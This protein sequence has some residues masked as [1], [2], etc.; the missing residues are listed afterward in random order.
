LTWTVTLA[1]LLAAVMHAGWNAAIKKG[2]EP[3]FETTLVHAWVALPAMLV[4]PWLPF[5]GETAAMCLLVS[6]S[7][8]CVYYNTMSSAYRSG[9]LSFAYPIMRGSAPML[10]AIAAGVVLAEWP[11]L[12][13]WLGIGAISAG[14][15]A[16]GLAVGPGGWSKNRRHSLG[17]ALATALTIVAYTVVDSIGARSAPSAWVYLAWLA[18]I[19]G[20][21]VFAMVYA[22][23]G[24]ALL[25][26]GRERGIAPLAIGVVSVGGY[27]IA[28]WAMTR[29][30]VALV[31]ALRETSVLFALLI[32]AWVLGERF[33]RMRWA[34]ALSIVAGVAA[35][36]L[37]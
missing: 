15:L 23:R 19:E 9:D 31:A 7:I 36:R 24:R 4:L 13:G 18:A 10:T 32:G 30:P 17:W 37:A 22:M 35:L 3:L 29:A 5:P 12:A 11:P 1:V 14:V 8:H 25:V 21:A 34:G 27:G 16:I 26:Y 33:G 28:L 2:R 20:P 6:V